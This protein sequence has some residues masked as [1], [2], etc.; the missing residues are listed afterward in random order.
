MEHPSIVVAFSAGFLSFLSPCILPLIPVYFSYITG[1]SINELKK[2]G[3]FSFLIFFHSLLF[4]F[5]FSTVFLFLGFSSSLLGSFFL[6]KREILEKVAGI[7]IIIL[8]LHLIGLLRFKFLDV[9]RKI[10][11][12]KFSFPLL[13]SFFVGFAFGFGWTP[14][15]GPVLA[16]ILAFAATYG[17]P[18]KGL[19]LLGFYSLGLAVPFII[20]GFF[21][22]FFFSAF[23]KLR[24]GFRVIEIISGI[25]LL[26]LGILL[27]LGIFSRFSFYL[28]V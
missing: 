24:K 19:L 15:I 7:F 21:I 11:P 25:L 6:D 22:N 9:E 10:N 16:A 20:S 12:I 23:Q 14:C 18:F 27:F 26:I 13:N 3:V 17:S 2:R 5:G 8:S 28:G 4:V 1:I